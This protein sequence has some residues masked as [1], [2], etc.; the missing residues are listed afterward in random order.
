MIADQEKAGEGKTLPRM[1]TDGTDQE[2]EKS[3]SRLKTKLTA[4]TNPAS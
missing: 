1:N 2:I 4:E 3:S